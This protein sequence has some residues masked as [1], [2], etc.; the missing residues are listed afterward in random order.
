MK[1]LL[2]G[3][4]KD[5]Q[6]EHLVQ[7]SQTDPDA[8]KKYADFISYYSLISN[9]IS[10]RFDPEVGS[11]SDSQFDRALCHAVN[12]GSKADMDCNVSLKGVDVTPSRRV[13][14]LDDEDINTQFM[15][16]KTDLSISRH[17]LSYQM[18]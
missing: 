14:I 12:S 1:I 18:K 9:E 3:D 4:L 17:N 11:S 6:R 16:A 13:V 10:S 2:E 15:P 8:A 5:F 7:W